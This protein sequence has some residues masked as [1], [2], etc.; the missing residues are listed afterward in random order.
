A[1]LATAPELTVRVA[2]AQPVGVTRLEVIRLLEQ[3]VESLD[4][5][6][7]SR[8]DLGHQAGTAERRSSCPIVTEDL[9]GDRRTGRVPGDDQGGVVSYRVSRPRRTLIVERQTNRANGRGR[10]HEVRWDAAIEKER[11]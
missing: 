10:R 7:R 1:L 11:R 4:V 5:V 8:R 6:V 9:R 3:A 2:P